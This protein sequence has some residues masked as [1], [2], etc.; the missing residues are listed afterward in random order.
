VT[1]GTVGS[2]HFW[3]EP[4]RARDSEAF[5]RESLCAPRR[6]RLCSQSCSSSRL[7]SSAAEHLRGTSLSSPRCLFVHRSCVDGCAASCRPR[8]QPELC[9]AARTNACVRRRFERP[10]SLVRRSSK[11]LHYYARESSCVRIESLPAVGTHQEKPKRAVFERSLRCKLLVEAGGGSASAC[12]SRGEETCSARPCASFE[13]LPTS[14]RMS[15]S[16]PRP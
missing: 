5:V 16:L 14:H 15:S 1:G 11:G 6:R 8:L 12:R 2:A 13:I 9:E 10:R 7:C 4:L 3:A